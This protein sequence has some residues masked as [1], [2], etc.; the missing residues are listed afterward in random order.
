MGAG[1]IWEIYFLLSVALNLKLLKKDFLLKNRKNF[2][3]KEKQ[4]KLTEKYKIKMYLWL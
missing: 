2:L 1:H 3:L 4:R